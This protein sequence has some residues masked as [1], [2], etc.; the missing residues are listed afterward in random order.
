MKIDKELVVTEQN[1]IDL[2][3]E[4]CVMCDAKTK[5]TSQVPIIQRNYY[6]EGAGQLCEK[7]YRNLYVKNY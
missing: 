7:C 5:Y 6:V 4:R 3:V 2:T 1:N